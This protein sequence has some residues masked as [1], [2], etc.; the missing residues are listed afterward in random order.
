MAWEPK[1]RLAIRLTLPQPMTYHVEAAKY[2]GGSKLWLGGAFKV[3]A[4]EKQWGRVSAVDVDTGKVA[5]K[6]DTEQPLIG[7]GLTTAGGLFFFGEGNG[8]FNALDSATR[9]KMWGLHFRARA[10]AQTISYMVRGQ[11]YVAMGCGGNKP[12]GF[13]H[14]HSV[15]G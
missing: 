7:G 12:I 4:S 15:V 8:S 3:I 10:N 9:K 1:H 11:K 13:K 6:H 2:P 14:G 5:W